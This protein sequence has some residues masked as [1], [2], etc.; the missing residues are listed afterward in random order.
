MGVCSCSM[1]NKEDVEEDW[2]R[3]VL[4]ETHSQTRRLEALQTQFYD[5]RMR[6]SKLLDRTT[7]GYDENN[8]RTSFV[9][10]SSRGSFDLSTAE[11]H[12]SFGSNTKV[13]ETVG[14]VEVFT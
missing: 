3:E 5:V 13:P 1:D 2:M 9:R 7:W 4:M 14:E 11:R 12:D 10:R 8:R 6:I